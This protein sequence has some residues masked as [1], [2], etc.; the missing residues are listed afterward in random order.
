MKPVIVPATMEHAVA[1]APRLRLEDALE[2]RRG[3]LI[4]PLDVITRSIAMSL[5]SWAWLIEERPAAV[6]G[7]AGDLIGRT[8]M[9]WL[10]TTDDVPRHA[11]TFW[12]V[13]LALKPLMCEAYP[14]LAGYCDARYE[15]SARW[16]KRLGFTLHGPEP[17]GA[18]GMPFYRFSMEP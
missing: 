4:D 5:H 9:P 10:L 17:F 11:K 12:K 14:G 18:I 1:I 16:L 7:V 6:F 2:I 13:S 15:A 3:G 8:A